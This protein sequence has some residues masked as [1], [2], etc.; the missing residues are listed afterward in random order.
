MIGVDQAPLAS[1]VGFDVARAAGV[2]DDVPLWFF[3]VEFLLMNSSHGGEAHFA[4]AV[5]RRRE[6]LLI[7]LALVLADPE[8]NE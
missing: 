3:T 5:W 4:H 8:S 1:H 6:T 2:D 7:G